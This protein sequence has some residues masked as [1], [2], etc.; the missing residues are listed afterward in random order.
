MGDIVSSTSPCGQ[1]CSYTIQFEGPYLR[2][3]SILLNQ[4]IAPQNP[5]CNLEAF[6][7]VSSGNPR[8]SPSLNLTLSRSLQKTDIGSLDQQIL[9]LTC[10]PARASHIVR[11]THNGASRV[12]SHET[13]YLSSLDSMLQAEYSDMIP[14]SKSPSPDCLANRSACA[15]TGVLDRLTAFHHYALIDALSSALNGTYTMTENGG[16]Q[17]TQGSGQRVQCGESPSNFPKPLPALFSGPEGGTIAGDTRFNIQRD[18]LTRAPWEGP[19]FVVT[20]ESLNDALFNLTLSA[21][22]Q[23]GFWTDTVVADVTSQLN[24]YSFTSPMQLLAPYLVCL[25]LSFPLLLI[26]LR[27]LRLNGVSAIQGGFVQVMMTTMGSRRLEEAVAGGCVGGENNVSKKLGNLKVRF[28]ELVGKEGK[29]VRAGFGTEDEV[30][31]LRVGVDYG[32]QD[33]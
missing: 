33:A 15:P 6:T 10:T 16:F 24:V 8:P 5:G 9:R 20:E 30:G 23:L 12:T 31:L 19:Q 29:G 28:G 7:A 22:L 1:N 4:T 18:N 32:G 27:S 25:F 3:E 2:C 14:L 13:E 26:G 21:A 11:F 17:H